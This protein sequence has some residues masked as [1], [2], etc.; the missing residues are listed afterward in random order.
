M[1]D[2]GSLPAGDMH[3]EVTGIRAND[4]KG[5][6]H[7]G[8]R[9]MVRLSAASFQQLLDRGATGAIAGRNLVVTQ[10]R[11]EIRDSE[12]QLAVVEVDIGWDRP[13]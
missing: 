13:S 12:G 3:I 1:T 11:A 10:H 6:P 7:V 4:S 5:L 9:I 8:A 2:S